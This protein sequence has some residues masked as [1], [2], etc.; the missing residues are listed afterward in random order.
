MIGRVQLS[1]APGDSSLEIS[2]LN[3]PKI[4]LRISYTFENLYSHTVLDEESKYF[5]LPQKS[6]DNIFNIGKKVYNPVHKLMEKRQIYPKVEFLM[7]MEMVN[8]TPQSWK[9]ASKLKPHRGL[10]TR[11]PSSW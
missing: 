9:A 6:T 10:G 3:C 4:C 11:S 7:Y 8:F 1:L 2:I 5:H